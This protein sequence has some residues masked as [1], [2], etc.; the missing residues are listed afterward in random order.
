MPDTKDSYKVLILED[1]INDS[2]LIKIELSN[3][4]DADLVFMVVNSKNDF[5]NA[6]NGFIPDIVISDFNL[7][8]FNGF[9]AL[10]IT[11]EHDKNLP[12]IISTGSLTEEHAADSIKLGAWDYVVKER[13]HRLPSAFVNAM[14]IKKERIN[15]LQIEKDLRDS[16][17]FVQNLAQASPVGIFRTKV[18]GCVTY[19]NPKWSELTGLK[20]ADSMDLNWTSALH[21]ED[22]E[23]LKGLFDKLSSAVELRFLKSDGDVVWVIANTVPE[24]IDGKTKGYIGTITD[25][26]KIKNIESEIINE[27]ERAEA[28]DKLKTAFMNNIS[29]E[30]R[31]PLNGILG[32][33]SLLFEPG[34]T[35]DDRMSYFE[36]VESSSKRL[37]KTITDYMDISLITSCSVSVNN[38]MF[39]LNDLLDEIY[40]L[41]KPLFEK[42]G[43][44]FE[45]NISSHLK[46]INIDVDRELLSKVFQH[47]IDNALKFTQKGKVILGGEMK[48]DFIELYVKDTGVGI[49]K[50]VL[51]IIFDDFIQEDSSSSRGYEGS[52]LGLAIVKGFIKI[53][54][55]SIKV[56]SEKRVGST[57]TFT[58]PCNKEPVYAFEEKKFGMIENSVP[59]IL[60]AEDD[61]FNFFY[62]RTIL[63]NYFELI[64]AKDGGEVLELFHA[65]PHIQLILMDIKMPVLNGIE[66][67]QKIRETNKDIPIIAVTA[68]AQKGDYERCIRSGCNEYVTKPIQRE[69]L[70]D[71][72]KKFGITVKNKN[73]S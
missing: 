30:I 4:I 36:I 35:D 61:D 24:I 2:N 57:F 12:F 7:P 69:L 26:T 21:H 3:N 45:F 59:V 66:V 43:L 65:N 14:K 72:I 51:A 53:L 71:T 6:L 1:N 55:G 56:D 13:L 39:K 31:T 23:K 62:L 11:I 46:S 58:I 44:E 32:F 8:Q 67:T 37:I 27:K 18:D 50:D 49:S 47:L 20:P 42:K 34:I 40:N 29:H 48:K 52:G 19:V 28:S 41:N 70:F 9:E 60:I 22:K 15:T 54:G 33:S 25:I 68:Y 16:Q 5:I 64:H 73:E 17:M 38:T 10:A 63:K